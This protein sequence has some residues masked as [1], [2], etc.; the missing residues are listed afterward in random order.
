MFNRGTLALISGLL[1]IIS[2]NIAVAEQ[3]TYNK[4]SNLSCKYTKVDFRGKPPFK[5]HTVKTDCSEQTASSFKK[6]QLKTISKKYW[7]PSK[8]RL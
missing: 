6:D 8:K 5:R 1:L 4:D 7:H 3:S 2:S